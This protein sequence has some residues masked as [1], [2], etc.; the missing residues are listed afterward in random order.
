MIHINF[1]VDNPW[2]RSRFYYLGNINGQLTENKAWEIEQYLSGGIVE[3]EFN[4]TIRQD[5]AGCELSLGLL[6]YNIHF[7]LYDR[8]HWNTDTNSWKKYEDSI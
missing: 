1:S 3:F 5:H 7:N 6:G 4:F 2:K 8:R